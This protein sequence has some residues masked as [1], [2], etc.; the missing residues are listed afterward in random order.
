MA[1][2]AVLDVPQQTTEGATEPAAP[3]WAPDPK[4]A[5]AAEPPAAEP[6]ATAATEP[7]ASDAPTGAEAEA[8]EIP[9]WKAKLD[10]GDADLLKDLL[11]HPKIAGHVGTLADRLA[12]QK[13]D[14]DAAAA[15]AALLDEA[16]Q[17]DPDNPLSQERLSQRQAELQA[18]QQ[19][20]TRIAAFSAAQEGVQEFVTSLP[21][22]VKAEIAKLAPEGKAYGE[23][24]DLKSALNAYMADVVAGAVAAEVAKAK[25]AWEKDTLPGLRKEI[26]A[27]LLGKEPSPDLGVGSTA[28]G[29]AGGLTPEKYAN[30]T[31]QEARALAATPA[32][33]AQIDALFSQLMD[34]RKRGA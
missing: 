8:P 22:D 28:A 23:P 13:R 19:A 29:G 25:A 24:G 18:A 17:A 31:P 21:A 16:A 9:E 12:Q 26:Q 6:P 14:A 33:K 7:A 34:P 10:A 2:A 3:I 5:P 32:G 1:E 11:R 30:M 27:E 20:Q 15:K 4:L